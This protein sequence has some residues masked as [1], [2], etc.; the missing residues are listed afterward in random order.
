MDTEDDHQEGANDSGPEEIAP[1]KRNL[2]PHESNDLLTMVTK[3]IRTMIYRERRPDQHPQYW[4]SPGLKRVFAR[5]MYT[6]QETQ[7][8]ALDADSCENWYSATPDAAQYGATTGSVVNFMTNAFTWVNLP[9]KSEGTTA[10]LADAVAAVSTSTTP[11]R[12]LMLCRATQ[13]LPHPAQARMHTL[14]RLPVGT[15]RSTYTSSQDTITRANTEPLV[16]IQIENKMAPP[17]NYEKLA[18]DIEGVVRGCTPGCVSPPWAPKGRNYHKL[19]LPEFAHRPPPHEKPVVAWC[20]TEPRM[21]KGTLCHPS[22]VA[23]LMTAI[24]AGPKDLKG[25]LRRGGAP[26]NILTPELMSKL[27][28]HARDTA[29]RAFTRQ[30]RW[31]KEDRFEPQGQMPESKW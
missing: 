15:L 14:V 12:V 17:V 20:R 1:R 28:A 25:I 3:C 9:R 10:A 5:H 2:N 29:F 18:A 19:E 4:Q 26:E 6:M 11:A 8:G 23:R 31:S 22:P 21:V 7:I 27:R 30:A 16:V 13:H 24:G